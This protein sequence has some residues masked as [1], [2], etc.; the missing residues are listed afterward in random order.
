MSSTGCLCFGGL[1]R[2]RPMLAVVDPNTSSC[3][4]RYLLIEA[5]PVLKEVVGA[6]VLGAPRLVDALRG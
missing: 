3:H 2:V 1:T 6:G 5:A 4:R